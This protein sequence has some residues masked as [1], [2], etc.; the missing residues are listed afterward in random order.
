MLDFRLLEYLRV[1]KVS[2][3][4]LV[5]LARL[6]VRRKPE[7]STAAVDKAAAELEQ[8]AAHTQG[9]LTARL[10]ASNPEI[11]V[12]EVEFDRAVDGLWV[13]TRRALE[14]FEA[15]AHPGL[16]ALSQKAKLEV[17][18]AE[19]RARAERAAKLYERLFAS[20]GTKFVT[21]RFVEQVA[22]MATLLDLIIEDELEEALEEFVGAEHMKL[23]RA[24]QRRYEEMVDARVDREQGLESNLNEERAKL[25]WYV[26]AYNNAVVGMLDP[27]VP[28]SVGVVESALKPMVTLRVEAGVLEGVES[29]VEEM[30]EM[31]EAQMG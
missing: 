28:E 11:E 30:V 26:F 19:L 27:E 29:G 6:L 31:V 3:K 18:L 9:V 1:P 7:Q 4:L 13:A 16:D 10:R 12:S 17:E 15:Y 22:S 21:F 2:V 23:L 8:Q 5:L 25:S 14:F 24:C 20:E